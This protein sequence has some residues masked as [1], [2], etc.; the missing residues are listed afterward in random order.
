MTNVRKEPEGRIG[1]DWRPPYIGLGF[2][3]GYQTFFWSEQMTIHTIYE[4]G[5]DMTGGGGR[6]T[7]KT[8]LL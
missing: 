3:A 4:I 2:G 7:P 5:G 6:T 1:R 8:D